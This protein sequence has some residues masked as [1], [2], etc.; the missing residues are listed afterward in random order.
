MIDEGASAPSL[1][2]LRKLGEEML[3][4][5]REISDLEELLKVKRSA[6]ADIKTKRLPEAMTQAGLT[7]FGLT[8]GGTIEIVDFV[9]GSLP[10][11][12]EN[13]E[14]ENKRDAAI[15]YLEELNGVGIIKNT[16]RLEFS[17]SQHNEALNLFGELKEKGFEPELKHDVHPQT[18]M[19]FVRERLRNGESIEPE[20]LGCYV[21]RVAKVS[22]PKAER[23]KS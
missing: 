13:K 9:S 19:A 14:E 2:A 8:A 22:L 20:K 6:A 16:I 23:K 12:S 11:E 5:E 21:G 7:N 18:L 17:K 15:R 3:R 4:L 10:K 1:P